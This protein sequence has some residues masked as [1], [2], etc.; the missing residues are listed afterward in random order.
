[1]K[2]ATEFVGALKD[3]K[4]DNNKPP[5]ID[6]TIVEAMNEKNPIINCRN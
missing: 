3:K 5:V 1:M 6:Q 2:M 4:D